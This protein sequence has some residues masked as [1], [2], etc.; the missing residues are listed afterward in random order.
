MLLQVGS[1]AIGF[2]VGCPARDQ[3]LIE[4]TGSC[5]SGAVHFLPAE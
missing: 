3:R 4:R 2:G 1:P 5:D